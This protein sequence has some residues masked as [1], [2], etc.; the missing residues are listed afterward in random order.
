MPSA[1]VIFVGGANAGRTCRAALLLVDVGNVC[2]LS[3]HV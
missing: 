2:L 3:S 1:A